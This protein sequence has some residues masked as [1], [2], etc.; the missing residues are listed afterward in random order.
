MLSAFV[1]LV[2]P[3]IQDPLMSVEVPHL[4][5]LQ[6]QNRNKTYISYKKKTTTCR[7]VSHTSKYPPSN[8]T[9]SQF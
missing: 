9:D 4:L 5:A 7:I 6:K 8:T 2:L 3:H 1:P